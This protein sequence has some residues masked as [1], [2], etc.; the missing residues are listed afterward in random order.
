MTRKL[1][2]GLVFIWLLI[3]ISC[4]KEND[5]NPISNASS[6][7][8]TSSS[9]DESVANDLL[10]PVTWTGTWTL[11]YS[12][13][14]TGTFSSTSITFFSNGTFSSG[15]GQSGHWFS[16]SSMIIWHYDNTHNTFYSIRVN[17][18]ARTGISGDFTTNIKGC[19]NLTTP[20]PKSDQ[21]TENRIKGQPDAAG[22]L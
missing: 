16:S 20:S 5:S 12:W 18:T 15:Q 1:Q 4:S 11:H 22:K 14:C 6:R 13:G 7:V 17:S 19:A 2:A 21:S 8:L 10:P 9:A 3:A